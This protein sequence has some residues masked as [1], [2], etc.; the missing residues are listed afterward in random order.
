MYAPETYQNLKVVIVSSLHIRIWI[1]HLFLNTCYFQILTYMKLLI[2][3]FLFLLLDHLADLHIKQ[4]NQKRK[5]KIYAELQHFKSSVQSFLK[6]NTYISERA[7][8]WKNTFH[9][10]SFH[11]SHL[12][13]WVFIF[14]LVSLSQKN[15]WVKTNQ[16]TLFI[17]G[18]SFWTNFHFYKLTSQKRRRMCSWLVVNR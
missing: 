4:K 12:S 3:I 6:K 11:F 14:A 7:S 15:A 13:N 18:W 8:Y 2:L 9:F 5:N 17:C 16:E 10:S 1:F